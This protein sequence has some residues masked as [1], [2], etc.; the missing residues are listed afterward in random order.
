MPILNK[1]Q[2]I[3][4]IRTAVGDITTDSAISLLEDLNDTIDNYE[5]ITKDT[6]NY[7]EKCEQIE[8]S[9]REKYTNRFYR[10]SAEE[11]DPGIRKDDTGE[12]LTFD[13]LFKTE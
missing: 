8:K 13:K 5:E 12:N 11:E 9:W 10:A 7:K 4:K 6:T 3:E 1:E 2:L